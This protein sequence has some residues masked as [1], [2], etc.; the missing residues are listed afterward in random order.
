MQLAEAD[1]QALADRLTSGPA[2]VRRIVGICGA[3][4]AG[5]ST[6]AAA[7]L[8]ELNAR[9]PGTAVVVPMDG[10]HLAASVIAAD[11]RA[12]RRGA[13]DTFDPD[14]LAA[15]LHRV[16]DRAEPVVYAP[17]YRREIEDPVAGAIE[18]R[19]D[20]PV[21]LVEGNY[22]LLPEWERIRAL[23]DEVWY[24][25][26]PSED[27]R[28][29]RLIQRHEDFGKTA[30]HARSHVLGSDEANAALVAG[31]AGRADLLLR[32]PAW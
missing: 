6:L 11:D 3:P 4:G 2:G 30:Q 26:A 18:V 19:A 9:R 13:P 22:L 17:E 10:F 5:K 32:W 23:L 21:V 27:L 8:A 20:C 16:R 7:L 25:Q 14:G 1:P 12:T 15:L 28:V 24:L 31:H 29:E